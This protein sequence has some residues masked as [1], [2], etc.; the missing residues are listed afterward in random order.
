MHFVQ[1]ELNDLK[2]AR[3]TLVGMLGAALLLA[4]TVLMVYIFRWV[5]GSS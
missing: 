2:V 1:M 3:K 4:E 5:L